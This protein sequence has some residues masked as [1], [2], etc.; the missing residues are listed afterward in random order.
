M[1]LF[2]G[3]TRHSGTPSR[4]TPRCSVIIPVHNR[5]V[6]TRQC[7]S[8]LLEG[9]Q[10]DVD[11]EIVVVDDASTDSTQQLLADYRKRGVRVVTHASNAGF[12]ASCNEGA[13]AAS[14]EYLVFLNNDTIPNAGW[15][16]ALVHYA[17]GHPDAAVVGSKLL[18][19]NYTVQHAGV[20]VCQDLYPRHI[21]AG[22]P[23]DHSAVN[24][25]RRFQIVTA[26]CML[27]R[28][29]P[30]ERVGGFDTAFRNG[31]EDV[32]LCLRLGERSSEVHYC[33]ESVL[34]H[35][36][37]LSGG[38]SENE[39]ENARLYRNRWAHRLQPDDF[40]YYLEDGLL[41]VSYAHSWSYPIHLSVSPLLGVMDDEHERQADRLLNA[42][43]RQVFDLLR[44]TT[45]L[46]LHAREA[47]LRTV[48]EKQSALQPPTREH[49]RK[50]DVTDPHPV[51]IQR[52]GYLEAPAAAIEAMP[53]DEAELKAMLLDAH[54]QLL[55]RDQE[56]ESL[57]YNL[58][59]ASPAEPDPRVSDALTAA[60]ATEQGFAPS[61]YLDYRQL[62]SRIREV[63]RTTLP[64]DA[65]VLVASKGDKELLQL[66]VRQAWHFPQT[67]DGEYAGY[68]PV[69]SDEAIAHLEDLRSKGGT[70]LLFPTTALWWLEHYDE[71]RGHL[72]QRYQV[73]VREEDTCIVF[74]LQA[75]NREASSQGAG[76]QPHVRQ[77]LEVARS[78]LPEDA[79]VIVANRSDEELL[80]LDGLRVWA[81]PLIEGLRS[82]DLDPA[83]RSTLIDQLEA[84]R[85]NGADFLI[86]PSGAYSWLGQQHELRQHL[87]WRY[88]TVIHQK[89]VCW[90]V[91]LRDTSPTW[92]QASDDH[93]DASDP[94]A[95]HRFR[96]NTKNMLPT[97]PSRVGRSAE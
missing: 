91:A 3:E 80:K 4:W 40:H 55:R 25:S 64:T 41:K 32:D 95:A 74:V 38:W 71:F 62:V 68:H 78:I 82:T 2:A 61:K 63:V 34:Y 57:L 50:E 14:S 87:E 30:F 84:L 42:R 56:I 26:A 23:S 16:D 76:L 11:F 13:T 37:S 17:E 81:F 67:E 73:L 54:E 58:Q 89:H 51:V 43:S 5:A 94:R 39:K 24:K 29:E 92:S 60:S 72:E 31:L 49:D 35:L 19:P 36:E 93:Q 33:H 8:A 77:V 96:E 88:R 12:A 86:V 83:E 21:Y 65:T 22:F 85:T 75:P 48:T 9:E 52:A 79:V 28:R 66:D 47:E 53:S 15:L 90:I 1:P 45:H 69:D 18:F 20:V 59:T 70:Y 27:V 7:L 10:E 46:T 6:L 97:D 44:E